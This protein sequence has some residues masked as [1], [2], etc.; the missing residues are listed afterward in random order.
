LA[1]A[2]APRCP[3]CGRLFDPVKPATFLQRPFPSARKIALQIIGTTV[4]GIVAAWFVALQQ[5]ARNSG[6]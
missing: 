3:N 1:A 6:H 4:V 2:D 5:A